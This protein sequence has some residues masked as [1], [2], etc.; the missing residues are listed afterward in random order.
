M[1]ERLLERLPQVT[2]RHVVITMPKKMGLRK[3]FQQH[4]RLYRQ[5][6][7][8]LH[9][10]LCRWLPAQ[11]GCHR[12][13]RDERAKALPGVIMAVQ[14]FGAGQRA[15]WCSYDTLLCQNGVFSS[16]CAF[17]YSKSSPCFPV[18]VRKLRW[19]SPIGARVDVTLYRWN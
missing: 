18:A 14:T 15:I 3:R 7:R 12:N 17:R 9:R 4:R 1:S 5:T 19:K 2:Y 10:L 8:L 6:A 13:R 11:V 16:N